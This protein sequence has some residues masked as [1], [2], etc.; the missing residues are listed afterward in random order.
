M[1]GKPGATPE[2]ERLYE[3]EERAGMVDDHIGRSVTWAEEIAR[4]VVNGPAWERWQAWL[5]EQSEGS[6]LTKLKHTEG[7]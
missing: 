1:S 7:K 6:E 4:Q 3:L 5:R 2:H